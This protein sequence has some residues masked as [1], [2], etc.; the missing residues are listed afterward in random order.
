[1]KIDRNWSNQVQITLNNGDRILWS[2]NTPVAAYIRADK[3]WYRT[4]IRWSVTT[5]MHINRWATVD[6]KEKPQEWFYKLVA[7]I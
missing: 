6:W 5:S 7:N 2:Y 1:M 3:T 4:D